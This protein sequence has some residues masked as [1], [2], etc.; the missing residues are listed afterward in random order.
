LLVTNNYR[1]KL[2]DADLDIFLNGNKL[3]KMSAEERISVPKLDTFSF[4]VTINVDLVNVFPNALQILFNK[5]LD[6]KLA[7]KLKAGRH[8]AFITVP[9]EFETKQDLRSIMGD[10]QN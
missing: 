8:G 7:G 10:I 9:V 1:L 6:I 5:T 3:G 2:K 4:P